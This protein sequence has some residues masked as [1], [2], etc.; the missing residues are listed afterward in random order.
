MRDCSAA[1]HSTRT[2]WFKGFR[3]LLAPV[4]IPNH[5]GSLALCRLPRTNLSVQPGTSVEIVD[6]SAQNAE[7]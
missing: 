2:P 6:G 1:T 5:D 3:A 4:D 7:D